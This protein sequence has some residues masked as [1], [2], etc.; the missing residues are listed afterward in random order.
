MSRVFRRPGLASY[1]RDSRPSGGAQKG[2]IV[3]EDV[4]VRPE[5]FRGFTNLA[6]P[7]PE[8]FRAWAFRPDS[9]ELES[10]PMDW[11]LLVANDRLVGTMFD[12][13]LDQTCPARRF[14]LHVL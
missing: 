5:A 14:A 6:D 2:T 13:A 10:M 9:V 7:S 8:E 12:L 11:D 1:R 3:S 4:G